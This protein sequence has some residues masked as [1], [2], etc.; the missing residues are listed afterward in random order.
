MDFEA[1]LDAEDQRDG[2]AIEAALH[3][4]EQAEWKPIV[5]YLLQQLWEAD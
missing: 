3:R 1:I 5:Q 2:A 4:M